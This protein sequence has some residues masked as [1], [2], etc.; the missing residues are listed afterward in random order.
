MATFVL[1]H[2][3]WHGGWSWRDLLPPLTARGH[4]A[5]TLDLPGLGDDPTPLA[6]VTL[7]SY[8]EA[9]AAA[10]RAAGDDVWL[11]GHSLGGIAV[12]QAAELVSDRLAGLVYVCA[13][14]PADGES[15]RELN[16]DEASTALRQALQ[17]D[18]DTGFAHIPVERR[19]DLFMH[20]SSD[21]QVAF[22]AVNLAQWQTMV[23]GSEKLSLTPERH[24]RVPR[25]YVECTEDRAISIAHQ[26][27]MHARAGMA[28]VATLETDHSPFFS[29]PD[30]LAAILDGFVRERIA[31]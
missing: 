8:A 5:H 23:P 26:R 22:S 7:A 17:F 14:V 28:A 1:V 18:A 21:E 13:Y 20:R 12:T 31:G 11:V 10:V 24:G 4:T 2:G 25:Y 6:E 30:D 29:C 16:R 3:A 19:R 27:F 15:L 9:V